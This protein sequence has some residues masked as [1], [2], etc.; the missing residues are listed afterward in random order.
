MTN[1]SKNTSSE[2]PADQQQRNDGQNAFRQGMG[3][4]DT[5]NRQDKQQQ[6]ANSQTQKPQPSGQHQPDSGKVTN[7]DNRV[8]NK[9]MPAKN[10]KNEKMPM[11]D[12]SNGSSDRRDDRPEVDAPA[13]QPE[14]TEK[15]IP[16]M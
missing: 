15:K 13:Q 7:E 14:K 3:D 12:D 6:P 16:K 10:Q 11:G 8:T 5:Q 2:R 4:N 1:K 9:D